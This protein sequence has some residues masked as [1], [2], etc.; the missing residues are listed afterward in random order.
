M[1]RTAPAISIIPSQGTVP[2]KG[3]VEIIISYAP[4][5]EVV[6]VCETELF[7]D[8]F[9]FDPLPIRIVG[10][11]RTKYQQRRLKRRQSNR[12][13]EMVGEEV[14][15]DPVPV[16][17]RATPATSPLAESLIL[18]TDRIAELRS[19]TSRQMMRK[20]SG[21]LKIEAP[22]TLKPPPLAEP[23]PRM[24][25]FRSLVKEQRS[26][27]INEASQPSQRSRKGTMRE[28]GFLRASFE[29]G[30]VHFAKRNEDQDVLHSS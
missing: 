18:T 8:Q 15:Q 21:F 20:G 25:S 9:D 13:P 14:F 2:G 12:F 10:L 17:P 6:S 30:S 27:R 28:S 3:R 19:N 7:I 1:V 24:G 29:S 26:F 16:F 11:A 22:Q 23:L 4:T 5:Q